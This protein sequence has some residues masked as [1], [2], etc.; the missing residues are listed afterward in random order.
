ATDS[1]SG[2][3]PVSDRRR[4]A[5]AS[6]SGR[7]N[8]ASRRPS[9]SFTICSG[10]QGGAHTFGFG[11]GRE[12]GVLGVVDGGGLLHEHHRDV[13]S[14]VVATLQAR[15]VEG[16]LRLEVEQRT[17]VLRAGEDVE[18]LRVEGHVVYPL[19]MRCRSS[20]VRW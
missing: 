10:A 4:L 5:A 11:L 16:L 14:D 15:V 13:V 17:L 9:E 18:E 2:R 8:S 19:V 7:P 3:S 6:C 1:W 20:D 12:P